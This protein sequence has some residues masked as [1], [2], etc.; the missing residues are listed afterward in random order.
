[1]QQSDLEMQDDNNVEF[2]PRGDEPEYRPDLPPASET[3]MN[4]VEAL[5]RAQMKI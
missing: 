2:L 1:M 4:L 5:R 3:L